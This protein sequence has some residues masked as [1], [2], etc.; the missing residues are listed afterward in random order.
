MSQTIR[1]NITIKEDAYKIINDYAK[2]KGIS[3][4]EMLWK[5]A[6]Q[7]INKSEEM[8]LL[9]FMQENCKYVTEEEQKEIDDMNID[10]SDCSGKEL[11]LDEL[12]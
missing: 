6:I 8:D 9:S 12:L 3:F 2:Q 4:S 5:S 10:F 7:K 11:S 1:K